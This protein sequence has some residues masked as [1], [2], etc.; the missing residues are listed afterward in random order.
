MACLAAASAAAFPLMSM[1]R[2]A[3]S[4]PFKVR[5]ALV[6]R[7]VIARLR[8][9]SRKAGIRRPAYF[10]E[11]VRARLACAVNFLTTLRQS[12]MKCAAC[13]AKVNPADIAR[14]SAAWDVC[15]RWRGT[16]ICRVFCRSP[17]A[18]KVT[19]ERA[20]RASPRMGDGAQDPSI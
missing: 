5:C 18:S 17:L 8:P 6:H 7:T 9:G 12:P 1:A 4:S 3:G 13:F 15:G 16:A 10:P 19:M 20:A 2:S 11:G 14:Y